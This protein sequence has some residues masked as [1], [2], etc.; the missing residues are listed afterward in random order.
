[1]TV[2]KSELNLAS[3]TAIDTHVHIQV[4]SSGHLAIPQHM[5][6]AMDA[7]FG[8]SEPVKTVDETA[9]FFRT[10][11]MAAVVFTIDATTHLGHAPNSVDDL[12]AGAARNADVLI[13]FGTVDPLQGKR[14]ID[15]AAR[16]VNDLGV[17][18]FKFHPT[19]QNFNPA[20]EQ[21]DALFG[22]IEKLGVPIVVHTGQTGAGAGQ[23][24]GM[25]LRLRLANPMYLDDVAAV[26][27][28]LSIILA[29]PSTP[30]QDEAISMA[31]HKSNVSIDLSGWSPK[32][33]S[34]ALVR[35]SRSYLKHKV[36]F[37]SDFPMLTPERW[38]TDFAA[39]DFSD[40]VKQLILKENAVRIL[41]LS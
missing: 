16:Q 24:G 18:G 4:D 9:E 22:A 32:Y 33:F 35:A 40:D 5:I 17:R 21:H 2:Y 39:L 30:W 3:L 29:H 25:G 6:D 1:M 27:P 12:V 19:V 23:P 31:T 41:G 34:E 10:Q 7:Y 36:M 11:N 14:A 38:L 37:G 13:P 28:Q 15:E 20:D 8:Q 26:H